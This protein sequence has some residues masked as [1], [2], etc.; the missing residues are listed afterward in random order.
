ML[1]LIASGP[2]AGSILQLHGSGP[3]WLGREGPL[4]LVDS[5]ISRRHACFHGGQG[6]W[7][8]EDLGSCNGTFLNG[9]PVS[10]RCR[11]HSGDHLRLGMTTLILRDLENAHESPQ[12]LAARRTGEIQHTSA[13]ARQT[14]LATSPERPAAFV[15]E[16]PR[17]PPLWRW[18]PVL[19]GCVMLLA[20][21]AQTM[22]YLRSREMNDDLRAEV[23]RRNTDLVDGLVDTLRHEIR[24]QAQSDHVAL[25][26]EIAT[27]VN[28]QGEKS[29]QHFDEQIRARLDEHQAAND[30]RLGE[31]VRAALA[32]QAPSSARL[33]IAS[34]RGTSHE[35]P[36]AGTPAA[37]PMPAHLEF[38]I[39]VD[40]SSELASEMP[41]AHAEIRREL[42][43]LDPFAMGRVLVLSGGHLWEF[44]ADL[45]AA[46]R[47]TPAS[48][49]LFLNDARPNEVLDHGASTLAE[50]LKHA[51]NC[52]PAQLF[53]LATTLGD[54]GDSEQQETRNLLLNLNGDKATR[55][56]IIHFFSR[57]AGDGLKS[58]AR[59]HRGTYSFIP[60]LPAASASN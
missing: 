33:G 23:S 59:E 24:T 60:R 43:R 4:H 35:P 45:L 16:G 17:R 3:V 6:E 29:F 54:A 46:Q 55:I 18:L 28:D 57:D 48:W 34:S 41:Q 9:Q 8:V 47:D 44:S 25:A 56:H 14:Q 5:Q 21:A 37:T 52:C 27:L 42:A 40:A 30:K 50:S 22:L 7:S 13:L 20:I 12:L 49:S 15:G 11:L 51:M 1:I 2:Q 31:Q 26:Q 32:A 53:I 38:V 36:L 39:L 19:A 58:I 10:G